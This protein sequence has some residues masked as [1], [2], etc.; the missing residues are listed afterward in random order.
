MNEVYLYSDDDNI[1]ILIRFDEKYFFPSFR[2]KILHE[3]TFSQ[4]EPY[5]VIFTVR[6]YHFRI[7][8]INIY[9]TRHWLRHRIIIIITRRST[10]HALSEKERDR[11]S[12]KNVNKNNLRRINNRIRVIPKSINHNY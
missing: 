1:I 10:T 11:Y 9:A 6:Y 8:R 5:Y 12:D 3:I 7:C 4:S 2:T